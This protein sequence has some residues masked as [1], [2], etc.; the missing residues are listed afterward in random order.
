LT[1]FPATKRAPSRL[2]SSN[3]VRVSHISIF[4]VKVI[5]GLGTS[6]GSREGVSDLRASSERSSLC[7]FCDGG[8]P[9][10]FMAKQDVADGAGIDGDVKPL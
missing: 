5:R 3:P 7:E 1:S 9:R 4:Q 8:L 10:P 6:Y 2:N